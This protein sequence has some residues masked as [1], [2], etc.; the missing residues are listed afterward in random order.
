VDGQERACQLHWAES[1]ELGFSG[2]L[3][4]KIEDDARS[5]AA[6]TSPASSANQP[7]INHPRRR[8]VMANAS[9]AWLARMREIEERSSQQSP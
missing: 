2:F 5:P 8:F 3:A 9:S 1:S 7:A 6:T 4:R